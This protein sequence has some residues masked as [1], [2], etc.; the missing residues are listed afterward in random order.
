MMEIHSAHQMHTNHMICGPNP[1]LRSSHS[2][3][4]QW[5]ASVSELQICF[6]FSVS[7]LGPQFEKHSILQHSYQQP[8]ITVPTLSIPAVSFTLISKLPNY[9]LLLQMQLLLPHLF[10]QV[11]TI[12][13]HN[14]QNIRSEEI[15]SS[16]VL[17][18]FSAPSH[19]FHLSP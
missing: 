5:F 11:K 9:R 1:K 18:S 19:M 3:S 8:R 10:L 12:F 17:P 7:V 13:F 4:L 15:I 6:S 2:R 16:Y 14:S